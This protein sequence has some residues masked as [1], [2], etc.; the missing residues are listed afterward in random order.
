M[1]QIGFPPERISLGEKQSHA[2]FRF[3]STIAVSLVK[4]GLE[5]HGRVGGLL[6]AP[7]SAS[8]PLKKASLTGF[9]A[10]AKHIVAKAV[11]P[12]SETMRTI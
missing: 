10:T 8:S 12:S 7:S 9:H 2:L 11:S 3:Y 1:R 5:C 6:R 4:A